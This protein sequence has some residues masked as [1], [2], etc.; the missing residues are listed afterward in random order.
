M[1]DLH[2]HVHPDP[3]LLGAVLNLKGTIDMKLTEVAD[4]LNTMTGT[5]QSVD[6][7]VKKI[8]TET[9]TLIAKI[10]DLETVINS[11]DDAPQNLVDALNAAKAQADVVAASVGTVDAKVPDVGA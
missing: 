8:G 6:A 4:A 1:T 3:A 11:M 7:G 10:G 9:D 2:I 5:L